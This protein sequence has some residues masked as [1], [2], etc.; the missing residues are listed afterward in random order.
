MRSQETVDRLIEAA[1]AQQ[2]AHRTAYSLPGGNAEIVAL[3]TL[4]AR[5]DD[6][7]SALKAAIAD[8]WTQQ[9]LAD[10]WKKVVTL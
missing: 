4:T 2:N 6:T 1:Q 9:E 10:F 5:I 7:T 3:E 8:G